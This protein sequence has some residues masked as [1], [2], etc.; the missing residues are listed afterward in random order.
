MFL[1]SHN[2]LKKLLQFRDC[3]WHIPGL[4]TKDTSFLGN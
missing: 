4:S 2:F 1:F 3:R